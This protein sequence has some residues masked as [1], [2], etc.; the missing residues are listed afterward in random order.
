MTIVDLIIDDHATL[1]R[2][3]HTVLATGNDAQ[4]RQSF[5]ALKEAFL[6]HAHAEEK[7]FYPALRDRPPTHAMIEH[8]LSEHHA[9]EAEIT[10]LA[11]MAFGSP[12]STAGIE[13]LKAKIDDHVEEEER[14]ILP[15]ARDILGA[16][17]LDTMATAFQQAKAA[18]SRH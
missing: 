18:E 6:A 17:A 11:A 10:K 2:L 3:F 15:K 14:E 12:E 5:A 1:D 7:V 4:R 13:D 8:G 9:A 16:E